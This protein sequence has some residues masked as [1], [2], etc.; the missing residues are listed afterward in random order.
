MGFAPNAKS[1]TFRYVGDIAPVGYFDPLKLSSSLDNG[2]LKY[3]REA[4]LQ[5]GRVAMLSFLAL[6]GLD[7]VSPDLAINQLS[8]LDL[9]HQLPYWF[10]V[11]VFEFA[12]MFAGWQSPFVEGK[13]LFALEDDYQPGNVFQISNSKYSDTLLNKE[14]SNG[15]LAMLGCLGYIAQELVTQVKP[16]V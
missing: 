13:K 5:H 8:S 1:S 15:R 2:Q 4:E 9:T 7:A 14:L 11:G 16:L 3:V 10:G 12:R 6:V